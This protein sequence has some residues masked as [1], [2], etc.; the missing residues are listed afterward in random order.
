[1]GNEPHDGGYRRYVYTNICI[2][3]HDL[4]VAYVGSLR[5]INILCVSVCL[6]VCV[7]LCL[8]LCLCIYRRQGVPLR[9]PTS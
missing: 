4:N 9:H 3:V 8:C 2:Y 1:M 6:C 5:G 7:C